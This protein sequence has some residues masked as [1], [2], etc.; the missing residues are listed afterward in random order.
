MTKLVPYFEGRDKTDALLVGKPLM[1]RPIKFKICEGTSV[2]AQ[3]F[4]CSKREKGLI[5]EPALFVAEQNH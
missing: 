1:R 3:K 4:K 5:R 2:N